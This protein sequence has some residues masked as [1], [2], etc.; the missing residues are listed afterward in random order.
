M[1]GLLFGV[2][3]SGSTARP[4][5]AVDRGVRAGGARHS[6][7]PP[8]TSSTW[9]PTP[10]GDSPLPVSRSPLPAAMGIYSAAEA[11]CAARHDATA[12]DVLERLSDDL[13][14]AFAAWMN[15]RFTRFPG[16]Y[17][18]STLLLAVLR[19]WLTR[20]GLSDLLPPASLTPE[21]SQ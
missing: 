18:T 14:S 11:E 17:L 2:G 15:E 10:V 16:L 12:R 19:Q 5:G 9:E 7:P 6:A 4:S 8:A 21:A 13:R 1:Q 20:S 3:E